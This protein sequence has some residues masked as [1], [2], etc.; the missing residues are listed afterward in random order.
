MT[1]EEKQ[2][3]YRQQREALLRVKQQTSYLRQQERA[4]SQLQILKAK[5]AARSGNSC[6][7]A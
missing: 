6:E 5:L 2:D 7:P 4:Q 3:Y 1:T